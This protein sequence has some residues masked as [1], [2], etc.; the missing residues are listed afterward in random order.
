MVRCI[1]LTALAVLALA[2]SGSRSAVAEA[3]ETR[4][5]APDFVLKSVSGSNLRLSEYRGE[6]VMLVF[7]AGWCGEC[8]GLLEGFVEHRERYR[9]VGFEVLAVSVDPRF[10]QAADVARSL[11]LSFPVLDD[12]EGKVAELYELDELPLVMFIDREGTVRDAVEGFERAD[13]DYYAS[14]VREL[15]RE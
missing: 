3:D 6:V 2:V 11:D 8:R 7:W 12:S 10:D 4:T 13:R 15:L 9:P 5:E 1:V 14:R